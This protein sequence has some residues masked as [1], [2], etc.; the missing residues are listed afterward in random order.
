MQIITAATE[1]GMVLG[2][3]LWLQLLF[4]GFL[5]FYVFVGSLGIWLDLQEVLC[6]LHYYSNILRYC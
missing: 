4:R 6:V 1:V 3:P 5:C 2:Y